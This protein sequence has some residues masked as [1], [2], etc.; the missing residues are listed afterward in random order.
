[1]GILPIVLIA[2]GAA[3]TAYI[4]LVKKPGVNNPHMR[5]HFGLLE[6]ELFGKRWEAGCHWLRD[7]SGAEKGVNAVGTAVGLLAGVQ[8]VSKIESFV[9]ARTTAGVFVLRDLGER[10]V[11]RFTRDDIAAVT[12]LPENQDVTKALG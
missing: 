12:A 11:T 8:V 9:L 5:K 2:A 1:M 3:Y 4:F 10:G 7:I 6:G